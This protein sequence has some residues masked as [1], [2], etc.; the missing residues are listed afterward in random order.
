[1]DTTMHNHGGSHMN[2]V[3]Q[4]L[5]RSLLAAALTGASMLVGCGGSK[6]AEAPP[7]QP[8]ATDALRKEMIGLRQ[9]NDTLRAMN[10]K[11]QQ[12]L[13]TA[14]AHAAQL[15]MEN[16]DL[17]EKLKAVPPP[18]PP[19]P[20]ITDPNVAYQEALKLFRS[21]NYSDAESRFQA[22]LNSGSSGLDDHCQYWIGECEFGMKNYQAAMDHFNKVF[23]FERSSKKDD[24]QMMIANSYFAMGNKAMAKEQ[25]QK[26]IDDYPAS[27]YVKP[28]KERLSKIKGD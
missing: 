17:K 8:S 19:P 23:A 14:N 6:Q 1:M 4:Y 5:S 2:N 16:S 26:L 22:L 21:K 15:E 9:E 24:A 18:P 12:D 20:P 7:P 11:L 13:R 28:A 25:Y 3:R 10:D 27:P